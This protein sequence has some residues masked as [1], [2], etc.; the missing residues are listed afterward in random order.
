MWTGMACPATAFATMEI[1]SLELPSQQENGNPGEIQADPLPQPGSAPQ[2]SEA[3]LPETN[4]QQ[5][6]IMESPTETGSPQETTTTSLP[7]SN[8]SSGPST[9]GPGGGENSQQPSVYGPGAESNKNGPGAGGPG[10][11]GNQNQNG[12]ASFDSGAT[13]PDNLQV[14]TDLGMPENVNVVSGRIDY[15]S[16]LVPDPIVSVVEKYS[17][18]RM[19]SDLNKLKERYGSTGRL[20]INELNTTFD[21]RKMYEVILGNPDAP[22]HVLIHAGIHAREYMTPLLVMKQL[23]YGLAFYDQGNYEG[24]PLSTLLQQVAVHFVPMVNPDGIS[25]SQ[26]GIE[27]I[28]SEELRQQIRQC[29]DNDLAQGRTSSAFDRYLIYWKANGRGV[30]LNQNFPANWHLAGGCPNPSYA[31]YKGTQPLSEPESWALANLAASRKWS[32]TVSYHSMGNIIYWDYQGNRVTEQSRELT[33]LIQASTGYRPAGSSGNGGFKDWTQIKDDP[34]PGVT[35]ETGSVAC[36]LP[37]SQYVDIWSRNK[38]VW[39]LVAKYAM[40]H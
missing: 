16:E 2:L 13:V 8:Q 18:D 5:E 3:P 30:D 17:Y 12:N 40:E 15:F 4:I 34:I 36:P 32:A 25:I 28:R 24:V 7:E 39:A 11:D 29:Y 20:H 26:F 14:V 9:G 10:A 21:G 22:K 31:S 19:V 23:E 35:I 38:M 27:G 1:P 33:S 37:V 6:T